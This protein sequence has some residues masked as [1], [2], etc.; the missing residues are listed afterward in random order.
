MSPHPGLLMSPPGAVPTWWG[1][2]RVSRPLWLAQRPRRARHYCAVPAEDVCPASHSH[3]LLSNDVHNH[4][5]SSAWHC[6]VRSAPKPQMLLQPSDSA[7]PTSC[8]TFCFVQHLCDAVKAPSTRKQAHRLGSAKSA[9][10][11]SGYETVAMASGDM[12][13]LVTAE[14]SRQKWEAHD[15]VTTTL[16]GCL[17]KHAQ[18]EMVEQ[19]HEPTQPSS[20]DKAGGHNL[21]PRHAGLGVAAGTLQQMQ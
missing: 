3:T 11:K 9:A 6:Q 2:Q 10:G 19:K 13:W 16:R 21:Q 5:P 8:W 17:S 12:C 18:S 15:L 20:A 1:V 14:H 7:K 4:V